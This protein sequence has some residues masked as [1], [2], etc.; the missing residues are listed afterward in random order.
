MTPAD[1]DHGSH[2]GEV[3]DLGDVSRAKAGRFRVS[4]DGDDSQIATARLLDRTALMATCA[5][6]ENRL[7]CSPMLTAAPASQVP[8]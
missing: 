1:L 8:G 7:H 6:E 4:I 3:D 5:D 2:V